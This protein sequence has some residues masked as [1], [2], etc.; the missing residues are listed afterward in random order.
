MYIYIYIYILVILLLCEISVWHIPLLCLQWKTPDDG[1]RNCSK[2][3]EFYSQ[4]KFKELV[5]IVG[6]IIRIYHDAQSSE[7]QIFSSCF[8]ISS[9]NFGFKDFPFSQFR[10]SL[11]ERLYIADSFRGIYHV[12]IGNMKWKMNGYTHIYMYNFIFAFLSIQKV[13]RSATSTQIF[14]GFPVPKSKCWDGS[15]H[16]KLPLHAS[17]VALRT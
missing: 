8:H 17:H 2:P 5:N 15:Q 6:F 12:C 14:L 4:N 7:R 9:Q 13:M 3:L 1:Q 16:S 10:W 11:V